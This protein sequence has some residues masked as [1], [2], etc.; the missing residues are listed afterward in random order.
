MKPT[1]K[2]KT[3]GRP[4]EIRKY[5]GKDEDNLMQVI[6]AEGP[7]WECYSAGA[8]AVKYGRALCD[9]ITYVACEGAAICGYVRALD[10]CGLYIYICDLLVN[11]AFRGREI[12]RLLMERVAADYPGQDVYVMSGVDGYYEKLRYIREGSIYKVE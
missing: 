12:G 6:K 2:R 11:A 4:M 1:H 7:D 9:S 3:A 8:A 5:S 10:D